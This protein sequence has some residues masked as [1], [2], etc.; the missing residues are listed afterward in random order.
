MAVGG[1][2]VVGGG[3]SSDPNKSTT[4]AAGAGE[5]LGTCV[6]DKRGWVR[7]GAAAGAGGGAEDVGV[8]RVEVSTGG[9]LSATGSRLIRQVAYC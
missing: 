7:E 2:V 8:G 3:I 4:G 9:W 5:G 6:R 1:A